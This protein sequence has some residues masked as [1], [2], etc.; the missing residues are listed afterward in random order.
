LRIPRGRKGTEIGSKRRARHTNTSLLG[1]GLCPF[2]RLFTVPE[3]QCAYKAMVE[4][5][6]RLRT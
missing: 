6:G 2:N 1:A 3:S 4:V 5:K